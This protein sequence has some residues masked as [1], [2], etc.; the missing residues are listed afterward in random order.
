MKKKW[1]RNFTN[2]HV[3]NTEYELVE[4]PFLVQGRNSK[5]VAIDHEP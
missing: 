1:D 5:K 4:D 3:I 2:G